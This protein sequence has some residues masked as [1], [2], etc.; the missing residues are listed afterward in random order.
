M[1]A[2]GIEDALAE[3]R[4]AKG[5]DLVELRSGRDFGLVRSGAFPGQ[6]ALGRH[7]SGASP[8]DRQPTAKSIQSAKPT[9][10]T[11]A[12]RGPR[13]M[14]LDRSIMELLRFASSDGC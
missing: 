5:L 14:A 12:S 10:S 8:L 9:S 7:Y 11:P 1:E 13:R 2:P 6:G 3:G 4:D